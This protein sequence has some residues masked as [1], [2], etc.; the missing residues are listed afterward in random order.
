M[1]H[2]HRLAGGALPTF[3]VRHSRKADASGMKTLDAAIAHQQLVFPI[4]FAANVAAQVVW[5]S[6][7]VI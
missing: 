2:R 1:C 4:I 6:V 5:H 7:T 3:F